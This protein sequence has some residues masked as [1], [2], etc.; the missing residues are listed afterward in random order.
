MA[1]VAWPLLQCFGSGCSA[2][3]LLE[4]GGPACILVPPARSFSDVLFPAALLRFDN[5]ASLL[6]NAIPRVTTSAESHW[7]DF[8]GILDSIAANS[9]SPFRFLIMICVIHSLLVVPC[10]T[11]VCITCFIGLGL[12]RPADPRSEG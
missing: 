10:L 1:A 11:V 6:V 12:Q 4:G 8:G 9:D 5:L 7:R 2:V 3:A